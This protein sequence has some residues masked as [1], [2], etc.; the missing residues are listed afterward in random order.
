[1]MQYDR[2]SIKQTKS[3]YKTADAGKAR[4]E[5]SDYRSV[6]DT[7]WP[8]NLI[9]AMGLQL[10]DDDPLDHLDDATTVEIALTMSRLTEREKKVLRMR[11]KG[12]HTL[13][14]I[15]DEIGITGNRVREI[16]AKALRK[17]RHPYGPACYIMRKGVKAYVEMRIETGIADALEER[18]KE[19]EK[20][21]QHKMD[22][23]AMKSLEDVMKE[24]LS[25][26]IEDLDM[27]LRATNCLKRAGCNTV[28]DLIRGYP[29]I[30]DAMRIRNL[31]AK[32]LE[33][34]IERLHTMGIHWPVD[35]E[36]K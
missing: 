36:T 10:G 19:L 35:Q 21:Y 14:V 25:T 24:Q 20:D 26:R 7:E 33:E 28:Q 23:I 30:D 6:L 4:K 13:K 15:G 22:E 31:G 12:M 32:S 18:K 27:S 34:V 16:E 5:M 2:D 8:M 29:T 1:M 17:L 3:K 9:E 11:Y